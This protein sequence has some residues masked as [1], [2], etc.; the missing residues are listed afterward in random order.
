MML[1]KIIENINPQDMQVL[2]YAIGTVLIA[3]LGYFIKDL[4]NLVK[5]IN[6]S[7]N[8]LNSSLILIK[9]EVK[10]DSELMAYKLEI[11]ERR[12]KDLEADAKINQKEIKSIVD[13]ILKN[14][15]LIS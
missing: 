6:N 14:H 1:F 13:E 15:G 10:K 8:Q 9:N 12:I 5:T 2:Y 7:V 4:H 11:H 3:V